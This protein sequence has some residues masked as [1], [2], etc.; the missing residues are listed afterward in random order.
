M[1]KRQVY[2]ALGNVLAFL[3]DKKIDS[4]PI[5]GFDRNKIDD[6]LG[7]REKWFASSVLLPIWYRSENDSNLKR[8]K[9][10]F[11][12]EDIFEFI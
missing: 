9:V 1:L 4:C 12:K 3:A 7:L 11:E 5:W 8:K 6:I 10:R 2:L